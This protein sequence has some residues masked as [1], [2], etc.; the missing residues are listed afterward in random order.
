MIE[1]ENK[2]KQILNTLNEEGVLQNMVLIGSWCLLFYKNVFDGFVPSFRTR[3]IDFY[4][5]NAK[6]VNAKENLIGSLRKINLDI[7]RD[8]LSLKSTF[9]SPDGFELEFI[10]KLN[11]ERTNCVKL[12][13]TDI[14]AESLSFVEILSMNYIDVDYC[15]IKLKV[16][17]PASYVLQK[18]LVNSDRKDKQEKDIASIRNV[19]PYLMASRKYLEELKSM[20]LSL[21]KKWKK[22]IDETCSKYVI[23]LPL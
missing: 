19:L 12:G 18:L 7:R 23:V 6:A 1:N 5:P 20:Y 10:T 22:R 3:D 14:Y 17:S 13:N 21:P 9:F 8:Y 16:A 2:L 11:R 15:G 4:V